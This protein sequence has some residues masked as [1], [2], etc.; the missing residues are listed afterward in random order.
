MALDLDPADVA[1]KEESPR[2]ESVKACGDLGRRYLRRDVILVERQDE[3]GFAGRYGAW[4]NLVGSDLAFDPEV[5]PPAVDLGAAGVHVYRFEADSEAADLGQVVRLAALGYTT[6]SSDIRLGEEAAVVDHF[7]PVW[8]KIE[9]EMRGGSVLRILDQLVEEVGTLRVQLT[10]QQ[11][12]M[13]GRLAEEAD[14]LLTESVVV[15]HPPITSSTPAAIRV[16]RTS[17]SLCFS[18]SAL[19]SAC[20]ASR[21]ASSLVFIVT[22]LGFVADRSSSRTRLAMCR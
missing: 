5:L 18:S 21:R 9:D 20:S 3:E 1:Q 13:L 14:V 7:Q 6:D 8:I 2:I 11:I 17:T 15:D 22:I 4:L 16:E 12:Q 10:A 19:R